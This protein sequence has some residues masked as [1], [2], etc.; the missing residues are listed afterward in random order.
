MVRSPRTGMLKMLAEIAK[1][2]GQRLCIVPLSITYE[3]LKEIEDYKKEQNGEKQ[4]ESKHFLRK[5]FGL[6]NANYG[7]VYVRF[8]QPIYLNTKFPEETALKIAEYQEKSTVISFSS[9]FATLFLCFD[10]LSINELVGRMEKTVEI[11]NSL[12]Y[13]KTAY[14]L[15]NL[16][17]NC[18]KLT[19]TLLKKG[20]L[21]ILDKNA[22]N[23]K[24]Q[25]AKE[26]VSEFS[27][28]K[29]S[30]AFAFAP[31]FCELFRGSEL[32]PFVSEFLE[33]TIMGYYESLNSEYKIDMDTIPDWFQEMLVR[34]F[35]DKFDLLQ[36]TIEVLKQPEILKNP[37]L[38]HTN[39]VKIILPKILPEIPS[40]T[41]DDIFEILFFI[42]KKEIIDE[43]HSSLNSVSAQEYS[44]K[45]EKIRY[46]SNP[47]NIRKSAAVEI[48]PQIF[49]G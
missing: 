41:A 32:Y 31:F 19:N 3:K 14:A 22:E 45:I 13:I 5:V 4:P 1:T 18:S 35:A 30:T 16:D 8:S 34:F 17:V 40:T 6:F 9:I 44:E 25:I 26:A 12:P 43:N 21:L 33:N 28:Y 46:Y 42:E 38:N 37:P 15:N 24:F 47:D 36:Q 27:F 10:S 49:S 11:L 23:K 2:T 48:A 39:L 7:P 29:N 20:N